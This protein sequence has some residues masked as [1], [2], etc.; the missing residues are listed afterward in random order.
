MKK[1]PPKSFWGLSFRCDVEKTEI[2]AENQGSMLKI[3]RSLL[4]NQDILLKT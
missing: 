4:K 1:Q 2:I 3:K